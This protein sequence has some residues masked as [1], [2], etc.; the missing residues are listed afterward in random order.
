MNPDEEL[1]PAIE[2]QGPL[3]MVQTSAT[4]NEK[5]TDKMIQRAVAA[6]QKADYV[7][8]L[9]GTDFS[10]PDT[11]ETGTEGHD[12]WVL[13]LPGN[14]ADVINALHNA[15][16]NT[17]VVL[18][19]GSSLDLTA[20]KNVPAILEAW[21]GGQAQGQAICDAVFGDINPSG[22]LTSTWYA[23]VNELPQASES[24]LGKNGSNGLMEYN[25]DDWGYT[26][27][28]YG[29]ATKKQQTFWR[30]YLTE[31]PMSVICMFIR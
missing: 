25:I 23:D 2:T 18:E 29:K 3:Y 28:Y 26:Y 27:M 15:N 22:H 6:A 13:T 7:I 14:Q 4:V 12:R 5:A 1:I 21:Y 19:S 9:G 16:P 8:F 30:E 20:I 10:K 24:Q 17:I 11:H 31:R